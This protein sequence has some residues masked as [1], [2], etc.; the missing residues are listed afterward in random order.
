M[1]NKDKILQNPDELQTLDWAEKAEELPNDIEEEIEEVQEEV[2]EIIMPTVTIISW[3]TSRSVLEENII[4]EH[5]NFLIKWGTITWFHSKAELPSIDG[6]PWSIGKKEL[7]RDPDWDKDISIWNIEVTSAE[8]ERNKRWKIVIQLTGKIFDNDGDDSDEDWVF[9]RELECTLT[10]VKWGYEWVIQVRDKDSDEL[11][12]YL[13]WLSEEEIEE[14]TQATLFFKEA[15]LHLWDTIY[16]NDQFIEWVTSNKPLSFRRFMNKHRSS[17]Y[18]VL[19][20]VAELTPKHKLITNKLDRKKFS[21]KALILAIAMSST[22]TN[23]KDNIIEI[24]RWT[25]SL[26]SNAPVL[27]IN[28]TTTRIPVNLDLDN[29]NLDSSTHTGSF[30]INNGDSLWASIKKYIKENNIK[31]EI[32]NF[33]PYI[34]SLTTSQSKAY[35]NDIYKIKLIE[36]SEWKWKIIELKK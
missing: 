14:R 16:D 12:E 36:T 10:N 19:K 9:R 4:I 1:E 34:N 7:R 18:P 25:E 21:W 3:S 6:K 27:N 28:E 11:Q 15:E 13:E 35:P 32:I 22:I 17:N 31:G 33:W 5:W 29:L 23:Y 30:Q 20:K 2:E 24:L 8:I 26:S